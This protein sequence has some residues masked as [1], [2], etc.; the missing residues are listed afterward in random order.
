MVFNG[1][2]L[3]APEA[4]ILSKSVSPPRLYPGRHGGEVGMHGWL[5]TYSAG[6]TDRHK[7]GAE[8][9]SLERS[10]ASSVL[11]ILA[12]LHSTK[13]FRRHRY[14]YALPAVDSN[15]NEER[16]N[17]GSPGPFLHCLWFEH[18]IVNVFPFFRSV[19]TSKSLKNTS[20][21]WHVVITHKIFISEYVGRYNIQELQH[22]YIFLC[23]T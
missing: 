6:L 19:N 13:H 10:P 17:R 11:Q 9:C 1:N 12:S 15:T 3:K 16:I 4:W 7:E 20:A 8:K 14:T 21:G 22:F 23:M 5:G 18:F 2:V